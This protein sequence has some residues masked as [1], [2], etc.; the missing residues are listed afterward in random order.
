MD[1]KLIKSSVRGLKLFKDEKIE[2]NMI[3]TKKVN[4]EEIEGNVVEHLFGS[5]YKQ[6]VL[7]F[8]GINA[9]GKTTTLK[10]LT[11]MLELFIQNKSLDQV[12]NEEVFEHFNNQCTFENVF[13]C[14]EQLFELSS[15][16]ERNE[17]GKY[18]FVAETLKIKK[19]RGNI[20]KE[21]LLKFDDQQPDRTREDI[22]K[23]ARG[24]LRS[25]SSIFMQVLL[26]A[27]MLSG[28]R[29]VYDM[30]GFTN[31]NVFGTMRNIPTAF[32]Q[33]LDPTIEEIEFIN[34]EQSMHFS[35]LIVKVKF[36][37]EEIREIPAIDLWKYL[38]SGT[39]KGLNLLVTIENVLKTG[40]Y[41]LIDEMENHLNK[42][43]VITLINLFKS[44]VNKNNATLIFS[45]HY[46]EILDDIDRSDSIYFSTKENGAIEL[47]NLSTFSTRADKKKSNIYLSGL[48]G[49]A[50][51]YK[52]YVALKKELM[53]AMSEE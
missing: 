32:I 14:N 12:S 51:K 6:N 3:T 39:I 28:K 33:Y 45:T 17:N 21:K 16:I 38:S 8:A 53:S 30:T 29:Y 50:P 1:I 48:M 26:E 27:N 43:V 10:I 22:E 18:I 5:I 23:V 36:S 24:Y 42:T 49:T 44:E 40:G 11:M 13:Y 41:I 9:S 7:A 37:N 46:S 25:D 15:T 31:I 34:P 35:K 4:S 2:I 20:S 52:G 47:T 19:A